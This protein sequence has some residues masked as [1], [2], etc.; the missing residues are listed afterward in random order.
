MYGIPQ[1]VQEACAEAAIR[2]QNG[3]DLQPDYDPDL[4]GAGGIIASVTDKVGPIEES[5]TFD[6]KLGIGFFP[7]FPKIKRMLS[8]AGVLLAGGGRTI[9]R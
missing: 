1:V 4:V 8:K 2:V 5:R 9:T 3:I 7:D 6:T